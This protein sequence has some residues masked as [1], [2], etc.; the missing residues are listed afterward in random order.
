MIKTFVLD[1]NVLVHNP[2]A[3]FDFEDNRVVIPISVIEELDNLK[4]LQDER[5]R[6]AR[7]V[8][9]ILDDLSSLGRL[10][11]G[12]P[13]EDGGSI[14]VELSAT[15]V[16][17]EGMAGHKVDNHILRMALGLKQ[18]GAEVR[19][20]SKDINAR[21]KANALGLEAEDYDTNKVNIDELYRGWDEA[22]LPAAS[23]NA[24]YRDRRSKPEALGLRGA[25][26]VNSFMLMRSQ[27]NPNQSALGRVSKGGEVVALNY[28]DA[29]AWGLR[30]LNMEQKF[31]MELLLD[32]S[33]NLVTLVGPAGTGKTLLALAAALQRTVEDKV[34]RKILVSRPVIPLG[35]DIGYLPGTKDDKMKN[36]MQ[37]IF[38]N[39]DYL[40]DNGDEEEES[41]GGQLQYLM[42]S[43]K[44]AL[45]AVT[46]IR[47]R[48]IPR[49]FIIVD[50]AQNLTPHEVKTIVSRAGQGTK[51]VLTGDP[52]QIDNPYLDSESNGLAYLVEKF[53]GQEMFG[54]VT[55]HKSER[56]RLAALAAEL[57]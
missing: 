1:T 52:Y 36:W 9:R 10:E 11:Q 20:I 14:K 37:P 32:D 12:V 47:G 34:Y 55:L 23:I 18:Q 38:D 4:K 27:D 50:E 24:F 41:E 43:N 53:K 5:G 33:I 7:Q 22:S 30:A 28:Q 45:E 15:G 13:L 54:H 56:S 29:D 2:Q 31:A 42:D 39:L 49:Q 8:S 44:L 6:S 57:L 35:K 48:S 26:L 3:L 51:M 40:T 25:P 16:L 46:Y 17:P 19:F 21:I